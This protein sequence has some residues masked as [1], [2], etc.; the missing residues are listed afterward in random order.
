MNV[1]RAYLLLEHEDADDEHE[2]DKVCGDP[3]E[4]VLVRGLW[5]DGRGQPPVMAGATVAA[6]VC[7]V[8]G[9][10]V[11][12]RVHTSLQGVERGGFPSRDRGEGPG[13]PTWTSGK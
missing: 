10:H 4:T 3:H 7:E 9:I 5:T 13:G 12:V 11:G 1:V 2:G 6:G 8:C